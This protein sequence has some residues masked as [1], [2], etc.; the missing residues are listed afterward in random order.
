M[1]KD[2][3]MAGK[4]LQAIIDSAFRTTLMCEKTTPYNIV[5]IKV[6]DPSS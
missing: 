4:M 2:S 5:E 1:I 6:D 3:L